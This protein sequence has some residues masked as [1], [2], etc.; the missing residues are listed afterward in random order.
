MINLMCLLTTCCQAFNFKIFE[1]EKDLNYSLVYFVSSYILLCA[2]NMFCKVNLLDFI[3]FVIIQ[4]NESNFNLKYTW[5]SAYI[6]DAIC[7]NLDL[8]YAIYSLRYIYLFPI[9]T[10]FLYIIML[11]WKIA[12]IHKIYDLR[13]AS[14]FSTS[15]L[16]LFRFYN[17][18]I[19]LL[20][21]I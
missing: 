13:Q 7:V 18:K 3:G 10:L 14:I 1:Y 12:T 4:H 21:T 19:W 9:L 17:I 20:L 15:W 5:S 11:S 8:K 16:T 2:S 6:T